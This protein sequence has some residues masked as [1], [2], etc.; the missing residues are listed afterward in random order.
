[1]L[2]AARLDRLERSLREQ[3]DLVGELEERGVGF[4][5]LKESIA[6]STT[7]GLP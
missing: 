2:V 6:T 4:R 1:V 5:S 7:G 3:M